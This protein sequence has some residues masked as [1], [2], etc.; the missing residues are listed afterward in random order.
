[1]VTHGKT[2]DKVAQETIR[3]EDPLVKRYHDFFALL[4]WQCVPERDEKRKWPGKPPHP[5]R[6]YIKALLVKVNE[7]LEYITELRAFLVTHPLLVLELGF[8]AVM[9]ERQLYGF[10]VQQTVPGARWLRHKLQHIKHETLQS[11]LQGTVRRLRQEIP[12]MAQTVAMDTKHIYAWVRENNLREDIADRYDPQQQPV[13]D[14]DCALGVKRYSNQQQGNVAKKRRK[15]FL[16]GYGTGVVSCTDPLYGDVVLAEHTLPFN[17]ADLTYYRPLYAQMK[18]NLSFEPRNF[19]A[20]AA[21][22]A[23][24]VYQPA[25]RLGGLAAIPLNLRTHAAPQLGP[26]GRY[27]CDRSL[28][29]TPSFTYFDKHA[30][31]ARTVWRCPLLYPQRTAQQCDHPKFHT[32]KGCHRKSNAELGGR[33]RVSLDRQ[34][35]AYRNIYKQRTSTE[36]INSQAKA[37]GIERPKLRNIASIRNLNTLI[38]TVINVRALNRAKVYNAQL[39]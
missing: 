15:E 19:T 12:N 20:D 21:F 37:L 4:E 16:W 11:L 35:P 6:A 26:N 30:K 33:L 9:A 3:N 38:Y 25:A 39:C 10:D 7:K 14:R 32:S 1:M 2:L 36:R 24:Y 5:E 31:H 34:S 13:G 18:Q 29:M 28:E 8:R 23:W 17:E 22:D 27:L